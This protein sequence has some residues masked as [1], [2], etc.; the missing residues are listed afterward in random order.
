MGLR[1]FLHVKLDVEDLERSLEFYCGRL[2]LRQ[3]VRY[4]RDDGIVIV[5]LSPTGEPP[6]VEL[7]YEA[8]GTALHN[9]RLHIAFAVE[10]V[11]EVVEALRRHGVPIEREP[12]RIGHERIAFIRDPDGYLIELNEDL[13]AD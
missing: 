3:I 1:A 11:S 7:W 10:G 13:G 9:D 8:P 2:G 12:F 6:G 4:D 5:Q